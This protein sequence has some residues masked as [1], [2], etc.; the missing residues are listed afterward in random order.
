MSGV[1][2]KMRWINKMQGLVGIDIGSASIKLLELKSTKN[3]Y[4]VS[5]YAIAPS[6][7]DLPEAKMKSGIQSK[8]A[9][10]ALSDATV[11]SKIIQLPAELND[12]EMEAQIL[13]QAEQHIPYPISDVN[14]DF[15]VVGPPINELVAVRLIA[16]RKD[17][18]EA[19]VAAVAASGFKVIAIDVESYAVASLL[20]EQSKILQQGQVVAVINIGAM[21]LTLSVLSQI[22]VI[23]TRNEQLGDTAGIV[24]QIRRALQFFSASHPQQEIT[25][26]AVIGGGA[27]VK[28][29][30]T[31]IEK[32]LAIPI[33][34]LNPFAGLTFAP[35][36]D[37]IALMQQAPRL[38]LSCALALRHIKP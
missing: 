1:Q 2:I 29:R 12:E 13:W 11:I 22:G 24:W 3:G 33:L 20:T 27:L 31:Q 32:E 35:N 15:E 14:L 30:L 36:V 34:A 16:A 37:E 38:A 19:R 18:V 8:R 10:I 5:G 21:A 28:E 23:F 26:L 9:V 17:S 25:G 4:Q 6:L 7:A